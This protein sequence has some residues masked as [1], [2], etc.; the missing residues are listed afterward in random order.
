MS[1]VA[2]IRRM[3]V[4]SARSGASAE[5]VSTT[6]PAS[7]VAMTTARMTSARARK[8]E[9]ASCRRLLLLPTCI[10]VPSD[11]STPDTSRGAWPVP[12]DNSTH[13]SASSVGSS[14]ESIS[15]EAQSAGSV[16][17]STALR[18]LAILRKK[19]SYRPVSRSP[20]TARSMAGGAAPSVRGRVADNQ[21]ANSVAIPLVEGRC[22]QRISQGDDGCG[23][24]HEYPEVPRGE[25]K[26]QRVPK[27]INPR[28]EHSPHRVWS[29]STASRPG[30]RPSDAADGRG[31]PRRS[32][33]D[34]SCSSRSAT[35]S[36]TSR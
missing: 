2:R 35:G 13:P 5:R 11:S 21:V 3:V 24:G 34:R 10:S 31:R 9:S 16:R 15:N 27:A 22:Q 1:P 28:G 17:Y 36:S 33:V 7:P 30:H 12:S 20:A 14:N 6:P 4:V 29:R 25:T 19:G 18:P 23:T 32:S 8:R 26:A